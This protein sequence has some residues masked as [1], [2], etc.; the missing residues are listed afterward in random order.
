MSASISETGRNEWIDTP[1]TKG[2]TVAFGGVLLA[3]CLSSAMLL[4][5]SAVAVSLPATADLQEVAVAP[6]L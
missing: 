6:I 4:M 2:R 5:I 1:D 3:I